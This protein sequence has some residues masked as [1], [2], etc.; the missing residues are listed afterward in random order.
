MKKTKKKKKKVIHYLMMSL[1]YAGISLL[2]I[3][4][5]LLPRLPPRHFSFLSSFRS[6]ASWSPL[7]FHFLHCPSRTKNMLNDDVDL[8]NIDRSKKWSS[9]KIQN[10]KQHQLGIDTCILISSSWITC[11]MKILAS[12][13]NDWHWTCARYRFFRIRKVS[14]LEKKHLNWFKYKLRHTFD[15]DNN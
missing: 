8:G 14:V 4:L 12:G 6:G 5:H 2:W 9:T 15:N 3:Q 11:F 10:T 1:I 13:L 7:H